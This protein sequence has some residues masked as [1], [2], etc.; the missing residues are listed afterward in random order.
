M[1][2]DL[3][4]QQ[5]LSQRGMPICR[6]RMPLA[7]AGPHDLNPFHHRYLHPQNF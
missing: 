3:A 7:A 2:R 5:F 1:Q 4:K 6:Q